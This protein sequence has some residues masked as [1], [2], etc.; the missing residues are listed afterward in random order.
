MLRLTRA[1]PVVPLVLAL[2]PA[3]RAQE[4]SGAQITATTENVSRK[5]DSSPW[6]PAHVGDRL[7]ERDG[8]RT[9]SSSSVELSFDDGLRLVVGEQ[10]EI[11]LRGVGA[12]G[13]TLEVT[14]GQAD[15]ASP[16]MPDG[17]TLVEVVLEGVR[18]RI[19]SAPGE[20]SRARARRTDDGTAQIMLFLGAAELVTG[21]TTLELAAGTGT[22]VP[23]GGRP[24][25]PEKLLP[26]PIP[27]RPTPDALLDHANPKLSWDPVEGAASYTVEICRDQACG[28]LTT[29]IT[30][31]DHTS[32]VPKRLP[33]GDHYW[34]VRA[35][36]GSGLDGVASEP[37]KLSIRSQWRKTHPPRRR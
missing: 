34:Q 29:R 16:L 1:W 20:A 26:A 19:R 25:P 37:R 2:V 4:A 27:W 7:G 31:L 23:R 28:Q 32:A 33:L 6:V 10:S 9:R 22:S 11:V 24:S 14:K 12:S 36:G 17:A 8:V 30:A 18:A 15:V 35:V 3:T 13:K 21:G 5:A